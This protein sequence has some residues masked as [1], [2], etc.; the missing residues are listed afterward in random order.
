MSYDIR[1]G[2]AGWNVPKEFAERFPSDGTHLQRYARIFSCTEINSSFYRPHTKETWE[3]WASSVP[4]GFQFSVKAPRAISHDAELACTERD[5]LDFIQQIE[6][7]GPKLGP[8]LFQLPPKLA[9]ASSF[10]THFLLMLRDLYSGDVVFEP[11][12]AS[13]FENDATDLLQQ[14]QIAR[15]AADPA[16]VPAAA[17]PT[18]HGGAIYFRLH[19]SPRKYY[20]SYTSDFLARLASTMLGMSN[21]SCV[22]CIFDNT[23]SGAALGNALQL[24]ERTGARPVPAKSPPSL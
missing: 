16:C 24:M 21:N 9:F 5:L 4:E 6:V 20:S 3:R 2:T 17:L 14:F 10:A 1:I 19:G 12:H 23:A 18:E 22:W 11:R 8:I 7:L 15:A 13:W